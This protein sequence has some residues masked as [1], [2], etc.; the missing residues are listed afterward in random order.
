M[1]A[2]RSLTRAAILTLAAFASTVWYACSES[3]SAPATL[4][5]LSGAI[6]VQKRYSEDLLAHPGVVGTA[7]ALLPDGR[8]GLQV[9]LEHAGVPDLPAILDGVPVATQVTGLL[10]VHSDP[11]ERRR[12]A[13]MGY[14][15]GH[16]DITAG[17][18]GARVR[19]ALGRVYILSNN[20]VLANSNDATIGDPEYQPGPFDGGTAADQIATLSDFQVIN[21]TGGSNTIDA[22]IALTGTDVFDNSVPSDDGYGMPNSTIYGDVNGDGL[23]D[24]RNALLGLNVQKYG[25]TTRLTH[26]TITG[27]NATVNVCYEAVEFVCIKQARYV[28]QL[29]IAPPGFSN[30]GDSG[31]LI[32]TDDGNVNPVALLFAGSSAVTIGNRIDLV[33]NRFGVAIDGFAPPPPGPLTD[34]AVTG[35]NVT[36][37]PVQ[38]HATSV[39][40]TVK[41]FGNQDVP[42]TF[43]VTVEDTTEHVTVGTLSVPG[44]AV[45]TSTNLVFSWTPTTA[46]DHTLVGH[47]L[48]ADDRATNDQRSTTVP[49]EPPTMDVAVTEILTPANGVIVGH[50]VNV[51]VRVANSGNLPAGSFVVTVEDST[52]GVTIGT[53]TVSSLA[54]GASPLLIFSWDATGAALG[55]HTLVATHDLSDDDGE[56]DRLTTVVAVVPK[57]TDIAA[58]AI[59]GPRSV[60]QGDTA[61]VV[62]T[63]QNVGEVDVTAPFAVELTDGTAG[64]AVVGSRSVP[65]L[66]IGATTT[67]DVPWNTAGASLSGHILIATQKLPDNKPTND[68]IAIAINVNPPVPPP[69][70]IDIAVSSV[71]APGSVSQ[72]NPASVSVTVQNAGTQN[73][74]GSFDIVLTD[75]TAGTT[76]GT[77]TVTGIGAGASATRSFTWTTTAA[78]LGNHTLVATQTLADENAANNS[79]SATVTVTP[80]PTDLAVTGITAPPRVNQGDIAPVSV[81]VQNIGGQD[82]TTSFDVVLTD[83]SAGNAVLGTQTITGLAQGSSVTRTFNWNTT[84]AALSGHTLFATQKL[85]DN[86][87]ANNTIGISVIVQAPPTSDLAVTSVTAPGTATQGTSVSISVAVQNVGGLAVGSNFDLVLTDQTAGVTIGTQTIPGLG[88]GANTTRTFSWNTTA[89]ALGGHTLVATQTLSDANAANNQASAT[90]TLIA[91]STDV[92]VTSLTAPTSINKGSTATIGVT[93]QNIG[94]LNVP[95]TFNVVLT[96]QTAG[97]TIGTQTVS[98]LA[99]GASATRSFS[100]NTATA[101]LGGHT[102]VATHSLSDDNAGNNQRSATVNVLAAPADIAVAS[103][104]APSQVTVGDTAPIVVTVQN[105]GGQ[106]VTTNFDVVLTDGTAGNAVIGTQTIA[107]LALGATVTRTF[108]WNT[109]GATVSG[110]ILTATQKYVD[111]NSGNNAKAIVVSVNAPNLHVGN[112]SGAADTSALTSWTATVQI[113][114]HDSRHNPVNGVT[115]RGLWNGTSPEV[116]CV[117]SDAGGPGTCSV[118]LSGIVNSTRMVSFAVTGMTL[119]GY[120]YKSSANHDPDGSSNGFSMTVKRQ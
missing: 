73:V 28:D 118:V 38:G 62:V 49:V 103:I 76:I 106:D 23:I 4:P 39:T 8:P 69:P 87:G 35:V 44:L 53:Q 15:V 24:D 47:Q 9:L 11:T 113:T 19:D 56:N 107:G 1:V 17:T 61:H 51:G 68:A 36:G 46:G 31:S 105:V 96:D 22:A 74:S 114:A 97:V 78:A 48:F 45:G 83:G 110:H 21:F 90:V 57:P 40:V 7:V 2:R 81:T 5:D 89:A 32:V 100:W 29:I 77:Q 37:T 34:I 88:I 111:N 18:A 104:T 52:A 108:G 67:V 59:T 82:V 10:M 12:P 41:N 95:S 42:A 120:V 99:V 92:A 71:T 30:G 70:A 85:A 80:Q 6:L 27:V 112:L 43:N 3:P 109:T 55:P 94:G 14:S 86:N 93:V 65:G 54:P 119:T 91:P 116:T 75:A 26:G 117:T 101:A 102:L 13:P 50:T 115:V 16:P 25:R 66:A 63:L 84:G 98:G 58:T 33:L 64:G 60:F 20:H 72:G 79:R